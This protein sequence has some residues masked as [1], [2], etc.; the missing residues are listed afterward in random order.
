MKF[1]LLI[2]FL[3]LNFI[4]IRNIISNRVYV[5][6][7]GKVNNLM[8]FNPTN[9]TLK[10]INISFNTID[11]SLLI[12]ESISIDSL[13]VNGTKR[14]YPKVNMPSHWQ[15][16]NYLVEANISAVNFEQMQII[17]FRTQG[18]K[19]KLKWIGFAL[20]FITSLLFLFIYKKYS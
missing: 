9:A 8:L 16:R 7:N 5:D 10:N 15:H 11:Q 17:E 1:W 2:C 14:L 13:G 18:N 20:A 3:L 19:G 4:Q 12:V 6:E